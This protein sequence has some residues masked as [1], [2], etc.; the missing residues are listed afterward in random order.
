MNNAN[1][2]FGMT[3]QQRLIRESV[4]ALLRETLPREKIAAL[5]ETSGFPFEAYDALAKAGW[6]GLMYPEEY[7]GANGTFKDLAIFIEAV[8]YHNGPMAS[9]Y[10]TTA[11]YAG[12]HIKYGGSEALKREMIPRF[13]SGDIR[14][15]LAMTEPDTG[16][17]LR[18]I[19][20]TAVED[21]DDFVISGQK[22][23]I[24]CAHVAD[25]IVVI[26]K[27]EPA[28]GLKGFSLFLVDARAAGLTIRPLKSL[29]RRMIHTNEL[30]FDCVRVPRERLLGQVNG[31]WKNLMRGL[32]LERMVLAAAASGNCY[33]I[34]DYARDFAKQRKAFGEPITKFQA[35]AHKFA[36]MQMMAEAS[37]A[38]TYRVADMLDAGLEPT[39]ETSIA[40]AFATE[41]NC[42]V[43]DMG[44]Q[45][46]GGAGFMMDYDMQMFFR[47]AR[48][49]PIGGGTSEIQRNIIAKLMDL[50]TATQHSSHPNEVEESLND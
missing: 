5:D 28:A 36:E 27:T 19:R 42:R 7:G 13:I 24:S 22:I 35:I 12:M 4:L 31:G 43:A 2:Y 32:N 50:S 14:L 26:A 18:S 37:R 25:Y 45:I 39:M 15:A 9:A 49:G 34:I 30:F 44:L 10:L 46:M 29:G 47:D 3:E 1:F 6:V 33:K 20:T 21:G 38:M 23:Y 40:K 8:A 41:N 17:D 48:M 11:V 16:S